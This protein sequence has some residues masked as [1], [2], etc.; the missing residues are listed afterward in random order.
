LCCAAPAD[1]EQSLGFLRRAQ[2]FSRTF[3]TCLRNDGPPPEERVPWAWVAARCR[4][5]RYPEGSSSAFLARRGAADARLFGMR[6]AWHPLQVDRYTPLP[7][8]R[9]LQTML[10]LF[11]RPCPRR[12]RPDGTLVPVA[13]PRERLVDRLRL[14]A[15][16]LAFK[17]RKRPWD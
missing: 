5:L 3:R 2:N 15:R 13:P 14:W 11:K 8:G 9:K 10:K 12:R 4:P 17:I 16:R 7:A 1:T 6:I